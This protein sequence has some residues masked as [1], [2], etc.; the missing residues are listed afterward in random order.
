MKLSFAA[1]SAMANQVFDLVSKTQKNYNKEFNQEV[2]A[3]ALGYTSWSDLETRTKAGNPVNSE[4][5]P[6]KLRAAITRALAEMTAGQ[7]AVP[8]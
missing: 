3:R 6:K 2:V 7:S 5:R 4:T 1:A 8:A